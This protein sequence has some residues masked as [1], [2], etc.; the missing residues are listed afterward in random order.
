MFFVVAIFQILYI[1]SLA[2][3][4]FK[5]SRDLRFVLLNFDG[6]SSEFHKKLKDFD[7]IDA[8]MTFEKKKSA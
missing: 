2:S 7:E 8:E 5:I 1:F 6:I 3:C 4:I